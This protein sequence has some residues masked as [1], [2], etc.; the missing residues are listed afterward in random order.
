MPCCHMILQSFLAKECRKLHEIR[1][2]LIYIPE[3]HTN[4]MTD[5]C[6]MYMSGASDALG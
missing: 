5:A 3:N 6:M 4:V 1:L 2:L